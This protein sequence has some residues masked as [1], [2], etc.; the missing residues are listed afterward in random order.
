MILRGLV[1]TQDEQGELSA[2]PRSIGAKACSFP[3][4]CVALLSNG[5]DKVPV[6]LETLGAESP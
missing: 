3:R 6:S 5:T 2:E 4:P 1:T